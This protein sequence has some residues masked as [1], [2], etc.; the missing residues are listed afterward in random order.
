MAVVARNEF[1]GRTMLRR[2]EPAGGRLLGRNQL[3]L[4]TLIVA[5][6]LWSIYRL[7]TVPPDPEMQQLQE[8]AGIGAD[9]VSRLSVILYASVIAATV[10]FQGLNARYYF[11]RVGMVERYLADT[12][13]WVVDVQRSV[14]LD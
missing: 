6:C 11:R 9:F 4:M 5:Y 2:F 1:R 12:P 10:V 14:A 3:G 7:G 8:L 13:P